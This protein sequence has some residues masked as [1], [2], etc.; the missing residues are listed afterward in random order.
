M[1]GHHAIGL[2]VNPLARLISR[3]KTR[4]LDP[5]GLCHQ[6]AEIARRTREKG[7]T[8][9]IASVPEYWFLPQARVA[10]ARTHEEIQKTGVESHRDFL[11]ICLSA[12]VRRCSLADPSVPPPVRLSERRAQ[13]AKSRYARDLES[14]LA[15]TPDT[16][17]AKFHE[18]VQAN[19]KRMSELRRIAGYGR[20]RI[21]GPRAHAAATGLP[22]HAVDVVITSPPYCGAQKYVRS[23][24]LE[25]MLLG[26]ERAEIDTADR[27]TLGTER[28]SVRNARQRLR[29]PLQEA[30]LLVQTIATKNLTRA[31]MTAEYIRYLYRFVQE[32]AR[33]LRPDGEAFV[34]LGT[35]HVAGTPIAWDSLLANLGAQAGLNLVAVLVDRIPSRGLMTS[36]HPSSRVI[37]D[38]RVVWLRRG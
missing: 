34:T 12:I 6:A 16:V 19:V 21:L 25:M 27:R 37:N 11:R 24:K 8:P 13:R 7:Y 30:D 23:L 14:A 18:R 3:V 9:D 10:L 15:V 1:R 35:G 4:R 29:T 28:L 2:D 32:L 17:R 38:E 36:R 22:A 5:G 20:A 26:F 31:L 33:V